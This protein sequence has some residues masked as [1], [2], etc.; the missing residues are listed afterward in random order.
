MKGLIDGFKAFVLRGN[1]LDLAV[2]VVIG[3]AFTQVINSLVENIINPLLGALGGK[4]DLAS[5]TV[6]INNSVISY[7]AFINSIISFLITALV[8]Y[9]LV[10]KPINTVVER[11][12]PAAE[13]PV[14]AV[15]PHCLSEISPE[16]T[17]CPHCTT[18]LREAEIPAT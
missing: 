7:G 13:E 4:P 12:R 6:T 9:F 17:R 1:V 16:A 18:W 2:A 11:R 3:A 15:C 8:I 5:L 14:I 10:V